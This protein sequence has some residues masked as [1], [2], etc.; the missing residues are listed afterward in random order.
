MGA[1]IAA[2][3]AVRERPRKTLPVFSALPNLLTYVRIGLVPMMF[4]AYAFLSFPLGHWTALFIFIIAA[5]TDALDGHVARLW[6][7]GSNFGQ[8]LDPIADK[9]LVSAALLML[10]ASG[11]L[12]G[13]WL[14][15]GLVILSRE[16]LVSGLREHL[17]HIQVSAPVTSLAK[18]KTIMQMTALGFLIAGKAGDAIVPYVSETG[19]LLLLGAALLTLYTGYGYLKEGLAHFAKEGAER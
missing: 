16:I 17:A 4:A 1:K 15:A 19:L 2:K 11:A 3:A 9:I 18:L 6:K 13:L 10:A 14:F 7:Q 5:L 12:T 8:M